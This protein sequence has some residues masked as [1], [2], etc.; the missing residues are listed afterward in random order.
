MHSA[1]AKWLRVLTEPNSGLLAA[2]SVSGVTYQRIEPIYISRMGASVAFGEALALGLASGPACLAA[3][4]PALVPTLLTT[5][6]GL[7]PN[8][9]FLFSFLGARLLGYLIFAVVAWEL[10]ALVSVPPRP[11][12]LLLGAVNISLASVLLG[13]AYVARHQCVEGCQGS[14]L[15]QIETRK[16]RRVGGAAVLGLLTGLN[17]CPPFLTVG[18]R[19]A[20]LGSAAQA[21]LFFTSFFVGTS[22]WFVPF[23]GFSCITRNQ[24]VITVARMTMVLIAFY[25]LALGVAMLIG[26]KAYGY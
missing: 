12:V 17:L 26:R 20:Q 16:D 15:V 7:K 5:R 6:P 25:Y 9:G 19:A 13:Y 11:R 3:C 18:V 24:G 21:I 10:G 4:G 8:A 22:A 23:T 2:G 1:V 14:R